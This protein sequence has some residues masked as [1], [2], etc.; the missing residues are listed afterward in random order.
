MHFRYSTPCGLPTLFSSYIRFLFS[1]YSHIQNR[2]QHFCVFFTLKGQ[3]I[4]YL[5]LFVFFLFWR[6]FFKAHNAIHTLA[7]P[8]L[9]CAPDIRLPRGLHSQ[10]SPYVRFLFFIS[11]HSRA[12]SQRFRVFFTFIFE[13]KHCGRRTSWWGVAGRRRGSSPK[14]RTMPAH[15]GLS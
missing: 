9:L 6:K 15:T 3:I 13:G 12:H 2:F 14:E 4:N 7:S 5:S 8:H 1:I 11:S 10:F